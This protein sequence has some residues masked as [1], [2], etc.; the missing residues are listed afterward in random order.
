MSS[1]GFDDIEK[2]ENELWEAADNLR[3]NSQLAHVERRL[4]ARAGRDSQQQRE[5]DR[6]D[7][8]RSERWYAHGDAAPGPLLAAAL[9]PPGGLVSNPSRRLTL[10][11]AALV[12]TA[13]CASSAPR[14][15]NNTDRIFVFF[16]NN[17]IHQANVYTITPSGTTTRVGTVFA[18]RRER[19]RLPATVL[20]GERTVLFEARLL[21]KE[22]TPRTGP[23]TLASG[24]SLEVSLSSDGSL[25]SVL[26]LMRRQP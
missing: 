9:S 19:L 15:S 18:M 26:P 7:A 1:N 21:T 11:A 6:V 14:T 8:R 3:A 13:A 23:V 5:C 25:M 24:D 20:A 16:A 4:H 10:A 22:G 2:L 17:T 12:L